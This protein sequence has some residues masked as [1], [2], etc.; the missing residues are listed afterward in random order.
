MLCFSASTDL[1]DLSEHVS[2]PQG[3][4][5]IYAILLTLRTENLTL[6]TYA[7]EDYVNLVF[8]GYESLDKWIPA[9]CMSGSSIPLEVDPFSGE[10]SLYVNTVNACVPAPVDLGTF[11][12]SVNWHE[13]ASDIHCPYDAIF[14]DYTQFAAE[15]GV[16]E[17]RTVT[18]SFSATVTL[19][20][21]TACCLND[22]LATSKVSWSQENGPESTA[23][24]PPPTQWQ[25]FWPLII[26]GLAGVAVATPTVFVR[27]PAYMRSHRK[28]T[29]RPL[30]IQALSALFMAVGVAMTLG[31]ARMLLPSLS[32]LTLTSITIE[33]HPW[34]TL[35]LG[36][37]SLST[38]V[39]SWNGRE[40][41]REFGI[42]ANI[43]VIIASVF[44]ALFSGPLALLFLGSIV[45][46]LYLISYMSKPQ[47]KGFF[48]YPQNVS[49]TT[50]DPNTGSENST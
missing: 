20:E 50:E 3:Y 46:A 7:T 33:G 41:A 42:L 37:F 9:G 30:G 39:G 28:I 47:I 27:I 23:A 36:I 40:W 49:G 38:G 2:T 22:L 5:T 11:N 44:L 24:Q 25:K 29:A 16:P 34:W 26:F 15:V 43:I 21:P 4:Y 14:N 45:L 8:P 17:N 18:F 10:V 35:A 32:I 13:C 6:H 31:A 19:G 48:G 12:T 1:Y